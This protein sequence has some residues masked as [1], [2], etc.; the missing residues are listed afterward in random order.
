MAF[1]EEQKKSNIQFTKILAK[2]PGP[3]LG[4][5]TSVLICLKILAV[6][7][8]D[9]TT[10]FGI[11]SK[12][13][14]TNVLT[15]TALATIPL[16]YGYIYIFT[17]PRME[18]AIQDRTPVER[19]AARLVTTW[20]T[21]LLVVIVPAGILAVTVVPLMLLPAL[22]RVFSWLKSKKPTQ[23]N[24]SKKRESTKVS[25]FESTS[26][27]LYG[28]ATLSYWSLITPWFPAEIVNI[29]GTEATA[30]V[31]SEDGEST[32]IL[33]G[34]DRSLQKVDP[35]ALTGKYCQFTPRWI[36]APLPVLI[37]SPRY[38]PCPS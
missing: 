27:A 32:V 37:S 15:G 11:L 16:L 18:R 10:A 38:Q 14:T 17:A 4:A 19:S 20:P 2:H 21:I 25:A 24:S 13:G 34:K 26:L 6:A 23:K 30:Y 36:H 8:W 35:S 9:P 28:I 5:A 31:I 29:N 1:H 3:A 12:G 22:R 33:S 7:R